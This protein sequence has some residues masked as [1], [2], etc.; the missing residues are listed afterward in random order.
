[1]CHQKNTDMQKLTKAE[2]E[3]MQLIWDLERCTVS[4]LLDRLG[5]PRPPHSSI[6][7]IV[8]ILEKKGFVSHKAYGKTHEYFPLIE[9]GA[10]GKRTLLDVVRNYFDGSSAQ[11][12]THLLEEEALS[13]QELNSLRKIIEKM[14]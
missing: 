1:L 10:Y 14:P 11:L 8:R 6:S 9:K 13:E 3:I 2:E 5:E 12:V 7:S 4:D